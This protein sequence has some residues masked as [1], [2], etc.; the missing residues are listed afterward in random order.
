MVIRDCV[1]IGREARP[2]L[3]Q[4]RDQNWSG[5]MPGIGPESRPVLGPD[6]DGCAGILWRLDG[7]RRALPRHDGTG[8]V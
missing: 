1:R 8:G 6:L 5:I 7:L 4:D 2:D 3:A